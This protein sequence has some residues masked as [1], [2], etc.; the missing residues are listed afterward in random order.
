MP[1]PDRV[2][3]D[4]SGIQLLHTLKKHWIPGQARNDDTKVIV[5][6]QNCG[7]VFFAGMTTDE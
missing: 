7:T 2:R 5:S 6:F 3:D 4:G 1:V